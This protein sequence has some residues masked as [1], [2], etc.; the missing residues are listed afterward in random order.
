M[1]IADGVDEVRKT[2]REELRRGADQI[3][4]MAS[5]GV[6]SPSDPIDYVQYSMDE[7]VAAVDEAKPANKYL[8]LSLRA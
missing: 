7:L 1:V 8:M 3:K 2:V 5:G 4:I 6:S